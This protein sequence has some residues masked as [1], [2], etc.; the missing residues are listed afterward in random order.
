MDTTDWVRIDSSAHIFNPV[1]PYAGAVL[2]EVYPDGS[3]TNLVKPRS[4]VAEVHISLMGTT[5]RRVSLRVRG[6][7][8]VVS[9]KVVDKPLTEED[10]GFWAGGL[11]NAPIMLTEWDPQ[12]G[13]KVVVP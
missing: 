11:L 12:K 8:N 13:G 4:V 9:T 6:Q 2:V 3:V 1:V 5:K 10:V 7:P